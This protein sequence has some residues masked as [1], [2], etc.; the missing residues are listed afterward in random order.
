MGWKTKLIILGVVGYAA[1][2]AYDYYKAGYFELPELADGSYHLSFKNGFRAIM[3]D[4]EVS[5][6][7]NAAG[8]AVLRDLGRANPDRKYL[9]VPSDVPPW[10]EDVWSTCANASNDD[11]TFYEKSMPETIKRD[12]VGARLDGICTIEVEDGEKLL[13][14]LIYSVPRL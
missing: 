11:R 12:L 7:S 9:G 13:R 14:G 4:A 3:L 8:P 10:F 1:Y 2:G 5:D 6:S